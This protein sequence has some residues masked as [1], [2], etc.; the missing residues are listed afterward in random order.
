MRA[1]FETEIERELRLLETYAL[2][3]E[4]GASGLGENLIADVLGADA[5]FSRFSP[6]KP[7]LGSAPRALDL[8]AQNT[9]ILLRAHVGLSDLQ[10]ATPLPSIHGEPTRLRRALD[11]FGGA[12]EPDGGPRFAGLATSTFDDDA[13]LLDDSE[14]IEL[15]SETPF[16]PVAAMHAE[17][18]RSP[19]REE[20]DRATRAPARPTPDEPDES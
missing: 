13:P 14:V 6:Q 11:D 5:P 19:R 10:E 8:H 17:P 4:T 1:L 20:A 9:R 7:A 16:P 3:D 18:T 15:P 12:T 2:D